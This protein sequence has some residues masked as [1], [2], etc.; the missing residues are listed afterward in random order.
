MTL[1]AT[2]AGHARTV[3][4]EVGWGMPAE[5]PCRPFRVTLQ[6]PVMGPVVLSGRFGD[7]PGT[8]TVVVIVP[9][10]TGTATSRYCIPAAWAAHRAGFA[11]LRIGMRGT[12]RTGEDIWHGGLTEDLRA[13]CA[14]TEL[15]RFD[16]ILLF[17]YSVGGHVSLRAAVERIDPRLCA[18]AAVCPPLDLDRGT[19]IFDQLAQR[20]YRDHILGALDEIYAATA[21]RRPLPVP[22]AEVRRARSSRERDALAIA[23]R[24]G[25]ASA[26]AYYEAASVGPLLDRLAIPALCV[27][28]L[29]DPIVP[30]RAIA[31]SLAA[32][33]R[34]IDVRWVPGGHLAFPASLDLGFC[35]R[36]GIAPQVVSWLARA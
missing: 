33:R 18:V 32:A 7:V 9:G 12:D 36:P 20:P 26:E 2:A 15:A 11:H 21:A 14:S 35:D 4:A 23:P 34:A 24:F 27:A 28:A 5:P 19:S 13:A 8:D 25:F 29:H 22:L 16:R 30:P 3:W 17:G 31:P 1:L 6:D 10:I